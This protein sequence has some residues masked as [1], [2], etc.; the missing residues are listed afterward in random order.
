MEG[1]IR[2]GIPEPM[3]F[4][5]VR[6]LGAAKGEFEVNS[7]FTQPLRGD[8]TLRWAP[9]IEY[10]FRQGTAVEFELPM[11][12]TA[13]E[14][15]KVA[16]QQKLPTDRTK[17]FI[18]GVQGIGE[19]AREGGWQATGVHIAG[20]RIRPQ[21]STLSMAGFQHQRGEQVRR[22]LPVFNQS[23]FHERWDRV[24]LGMELNWKGRHIESRQ[25]LWMPQVHLKVYERLN[26]QFGAG[27]S[28]RP[29]TR[30]PVVSW[31][32]IREL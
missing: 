31:R 18:H 10:A 6:P 20:V 25:W 12:G 32:L 9:E 26:L 22:T 14:N 27:Y 24:V 11:A 30:T 2:L 15:Y 17:P 29:G 21:W 13:I 4:D 28:A 8:R 19:V 3:V 7:F 23:L 5:L 1:S 16:L